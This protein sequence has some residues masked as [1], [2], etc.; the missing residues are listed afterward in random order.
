MKLFNRIFNIGLLTATTVIA[1]SS[2]SDFLDVKPYT[3]ITEEQMFSDPE[4]AE[5]N[6][7]SCYKGWRSMFTDRYIWEL[8][9][10]TDEIQSGAYQALKEDGMKRGSLDRYDALL[11]SDLYYVSDQWGNRWT[12]VSE[13]AKIIKALKAQAD[14]DAYVAKIYGEACFIRGGLDL[15]LAMVF[16][17][18]PILDLDRIDDLGY[19]RQPLADV[20]SFI[21]NDFK[22]AAKY[23]P[24]ENEPGRATSWAALML[25]GYAQM[26]APEE[27]GLRDF[28]AAAEALGKVVNDGPFALV[29]Y[30]DLWDYSY[31]NTKE[32]IF[33]WQFSPTY[34]DNNMI[35]FQIGSRAVAAMGADQCYMSGYDH[36][37]PTKWA[38]SDITDGGIWED[39]DIRKEEAIRYDFEWFGQYPNLESISWE[40]IGDDHDELKPHIKKYEDFRTDIHSGLG[41]NNMWYSGKDIP[42]LRLGNAILLY[43]E[44]LNEIGQTAEAVKYVNDVRRRAWEGSLPADKTWSS[45]M[46]KD[47]FRDEIMTERVRELFGE[48]WRKFDLVRTGHFVE[49][50]LARNEWAKRSGTIAEYNK[51]WPIPLTEID[52]NTD[53]DA[54]DQNEGYR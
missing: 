22:E 43:A 52:Q 24:T 11:T 12:R 32:A 37:V 45:G 49:Y 23:C 28:T 16:G 8:M 6:L 44:C 38:Y 17:R 4:Y 19:G 50:V 3:S 51:V 26:A 54:S 9:V 36:A 35:Q 31:S 15:E 25:Q 47:Q 46:T 13:A 27:T 21:I 5:S 20:W 48:R 18:I 2:C 34:P 41:Y 40:D 33:E 29:D 1:L 42:F 39:G 53:I 14:D 30:Y 7:L 10:G